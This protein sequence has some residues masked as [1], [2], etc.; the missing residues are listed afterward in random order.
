MNRRKAILT[1]SAAVAALIAAGGG[2]KWYRIAKVPDLEFVSRSKGL[3]DALAET[4]I[5]ATD[6]PGA[7]DAGVGDFIGKMV[8]H[9][10]NRKEQ[11]QFVNGLK[12]VQRYCERTF[13]HGYEQCTAVQQEQ[14]MKDLERSGRPR[15]GIAG[16]VEARLVGR[17]FFSLLKA[18]TVEGYCT[19]QA[20]ATKGLAYFYIPGSYKGCTP[21]LPGQR[22][23]ATN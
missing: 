21:L 22:A 1:G 16:K 23:W 5:P 17:S 7:K 20:G 3:L 14:V 6:V 12:D 10:T 2:Y 19:S 18:Y 13:G 11:N 8:V 9:C 15:P 4:I